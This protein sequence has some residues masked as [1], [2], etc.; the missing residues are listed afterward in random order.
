M[1]IFDKLKKNF[2]DS[3]ENSASFNDPVLDEIKRCMVYAPLTHS[4]YKMA[5][6]IYYKGHTSYR[7]FYRMVYFRNAQ[8]VE[9][10]MIAAEKKAYE[11]CLIE[12]TLVRFFYDERKYIEIPFQVFSNKKNLTASSKSRQDWDR[13]NMKRLLSINPSLANVNDKKIVVDKDAILVAINKDLTNAFKNASDELKADKEVVLAAVKK[14]GYALEYASDELKADKEVVL[15]AVKNHGSSL[16]YA[17]DELKAD[18]EVILTAVK[19]YGYALEYASDELKADKEVV[20]EAVKNDGHALKYASDELKA[21]KEVVL[22]AVK[23]YGHALDYASDGL[24]ADKEVV[25]AAVKKSGYSLKYAS[26]ELKADKEVV[27]AA[28]KN[29]GHALD[30]ASDELKADKE[31]VLAAVKNH[32]DA[33][34]YASD[35]LKADEDVVLAAAKTSEEALEAEREKEKYHEQVREAVVNGNLSDIIDIVDLMIG[36]HVQGA[37]DY[38]DMI[39]QRFVVGDEKFDALDF[40]TLMRFYKLYADKDYIGKHDVAIHGYS[41]E[42]MKKASTPN[43]FAILAR[44]T[45]N[46]LK[47]HDLAKECLQKALDIDPDFKAL[48]SI[49]LTVA[50]A[51]YLNDKTWA[52]KIFQQCVEKNP[53]SSDFSALCESIADNDFLGDKVWA[54]ELIKQHIASEDQVNYLHIIDLASMDYYLA[55]QKLSMEIFRNA[56]ERCNDY[57]SHFDLLCRINNGSEIF[58][59]IFKEFAKEVVTQFDNDTQKDQFWNHF[60]YGNELDKDFLNDVKNSSIAELKQK[61]GSHNAN[62]FDDDLSL[63][64]PTGDDDLSL[65]EPTGDD[66]LSLDE[67]TGDDDLLLDEPTGDDDLLLD[68]M[69][70]TDSD[71]PRHSLDDCLDWIRKMQEDVITLDDPID[72][73]EKGLYDVSLKSVRKIMDR[74][75]LPAQTNTEYFESFKQHIAMKQGSSAVS[76]NEELTLEL[77]TPMEQQQAPSTDLKQLYSQG[78]ASGEINP[79]EVNFTDFEK[80]NNQPKEVDYKALYAQMIGEG[81]INPAETTFNE[82]LLISKLFSGV[83]EDHYK[84]VYSQKIASGEIDPSETTYDEI[85]RIANIVNAMGR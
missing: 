76:A 17:S 11:G 13:D 66:D 54:K 64:E 83:A 6:I 42:L 55:D 40:N 23:N 58:Q 16:K 22:A 1:G 7:S 71:Q 68:E 80:A 10:I 27:L 61:Y 36:N 56:K 35:E 37:K 49:A 26:D 79:A 59:P 39:L 70:G 50:D 15:A 31:V 43:E 20:L 19:N 9:K 32:E 45:L 46:Y 82:V 44:S 60:Q 5:E 14:H 77:D 52:R 30:Y 33:L 34:D 48:K 73:F 78:I 85:V 47:N 65:D 18:K 41:K 57:K 8:R 51:D 12:N 67:P 2:T 72:E 3:D 4:E 74:S 25:L 29:D 24:K 63:D 81:Q 62:S 21:D 84:A 69:L 28:V 38:G 53:S 75:D